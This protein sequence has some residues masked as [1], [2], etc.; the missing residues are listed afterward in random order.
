MPFLDGPSAGWSRPE[1]QSPASKG[2]SKSC[3]WTSHIADE[4]L[5][6]LHLQVSVSSSLAASASAGESVSLLV[7]DG[8]EVR[9]PMAGVQSLQLA[10]CIPCP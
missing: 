9:L 3:C 10:V 5:W 6:H 2:V 1:L 4:P 7:R 8:L